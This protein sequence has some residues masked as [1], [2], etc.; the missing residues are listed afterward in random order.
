[1][2]EQILPGSE[3]EWGQREGAVGRAEKCP[4]Q[5]KVLWCRIYVVI[6]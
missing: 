3:G 2:P 5:N 1:M 6:A 4:P